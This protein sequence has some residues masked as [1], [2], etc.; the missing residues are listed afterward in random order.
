MGA[1]ATKEAYVICLQE[2]WLDPAD[3]ADITSMIDGDW[4]YQNNS[5][6]KGRGITTIYKSEFKLDKNITKTN[7]QMT[8][9]MSES[10]DVI[11]IYRS[12]GANTSDFLEDINAL[13]TRSKH[14]LIMGDFNIC[15][16][17]EYFHEIYENLR[18]LGFKQLVEKPTHIE[19][20]LIDC[21]FI[22][23]PNNEIIYTVTQQA[24]Y[25]TDH[26][27]IKINKGNTYCLFMKKKNIFILLVPDE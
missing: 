15:H 13:Y 6:G 7:Y 11:N 18:K 4:Y 5:I 9:I 3:D 19:G 25:F 24:Q 21:V 17:K 26:D 2:T 16:T 10:A 23:C 22:A 12:S 8:K 27:L 14:T 20:R 1:S